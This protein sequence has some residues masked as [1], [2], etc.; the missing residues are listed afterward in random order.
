MPKEQPAETA[1]ATIYKKNALSLMMF[2]FV[3]GT[4]TTIHTV[5][6]KDAIDSFMEDFRL[7]DDDV[8]RGSLEVIY[9]RM[10]KDL[11]KKDGKK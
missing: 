2:G 1:I 9:L 10:K 4:I 8:N 11:Q 7:T 5:S 3:R 6:V